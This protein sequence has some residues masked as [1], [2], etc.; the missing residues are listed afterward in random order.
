MKQITNNSQQAFSLIETMVVVSIIAITT[1]LAVPAFEKSISRTQ[2]E[3][4][5]NIVYDVFQ[6]AR[7]TAITHGQYISICPSPNGQICSR[8]WQQGLMAFIDIDRDRQLSGNEKII[9]FQPTTSATTLHGNQR[10]FTY[11]P[12]GSIKGRLGSL[13]VCPTKNSGKNLS[14]RLFVSQMGR[15]RIETKSDST[16]D[17]CKSSFKY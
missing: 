5:T 8:E 13:V 3:S 17:S 16:R 15:V 6:L 4:K 10:Y 7:S 11:N 12:L 9:T 2:I 14:T 1:S